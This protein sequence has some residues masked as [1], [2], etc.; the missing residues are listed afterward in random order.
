MSASCQ[1]TSSPG[2]ISAECAFPSDTMATGFQMIAQSSNS[3]KVHIL[4]VNQSMDLQTPVT[5]EVE[6]GV[7]Q[8]TIFAIRERTGIIGS[9][10]ID[11]V[12][13]VKGML[14]KTTLSLNFT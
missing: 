5:V 10:V 13:E 3:S 8:V 9:S 2:I 14:K 7:Y 6:S 11:V 4:H 12:L 1:I